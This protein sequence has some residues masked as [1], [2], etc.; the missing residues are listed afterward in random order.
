MN[1]YD[2]LGVSVHATSEE[3]RQKYKT[4]AQIHHPDKGGDE[5]KFK[6][7]K[8][9]YEILSDPIRRTEYDTTGKFGTDTSIKDEALH[10]L[11]QMLFSII[12]NFNP[13]QDNLIQLMTNKVTELKQECTSNIDV[14]NN[15][16]AHLN[17]IV[18]RLKI[19]TDNENLLLGFVNTQID[20]RKN[21]F[22]TFTRRIQICDLQFEILKD[23]EYGLI[24]L[25]GAPTEN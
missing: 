4:L 11:A 16:V 2:E 14:C 7:I 8:F 10:N 1:P 21:E 22:A 3:I 20:I 18:A 15:F 24:E 13:E 17:K 12:P 23:Y 5:E 6:R 25:P 9:A 19:K